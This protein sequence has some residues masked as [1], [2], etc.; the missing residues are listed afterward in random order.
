MLDGLAVVLPYPSLEKIQER[1]SLAFSARID[2]GVVDSHDWGRHGTRRSERRAQIGARQLCNNLFKCP[3][4]EHFVFD[5]GSADSSAK[6]VAAKVLERLAVRSGRR[7][8]FRAEIFEAA[9]VDFIRS[10][11]SDDVDDAAGGPP[12]FRVC[13]ACDNLKFLDSVQCD[14]NCSALSAELLAEEA[15]VVITAIKADVIEYTALSVKVDLVSIRPLGNRHTGCQRQQIFKLAP[16]HWRRADREFAQCRG[17]FSFCRFDDWYVR[18]DDLLRNRRYLHGYRQRNGLAYSEVHI[19][20]NDGGEPGFADSE[21]V[22]AWRK[23]QEGKVTVRVG[24][25]RL[26]E[27]G[28]QVLCFNGRTRDASAF[29]IEHVSLHGPRGD[30]RLAP[31]IR[32]KSQR[33]CQT[34]ERTQHFSHF[35]SPRHHNPIH[36]SPGIPQKVEAARKE[37]MNDAKKFMPGR[38]ESTRAASVETL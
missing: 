20:L 21:R 23:T 10:G 19:F 16:Q 28:R 32:S 34:K 35:V 9:S 15:V 17:R 33:E 31:P 36:A 22:A 24:G 26:H 3:E 5:D 7:K 4:D 18:D 8:R 27:I 1:N 30:L 29:F 11:L 38:S 6:L 2:H 37:T 12:K 25:V 14:V 13:A